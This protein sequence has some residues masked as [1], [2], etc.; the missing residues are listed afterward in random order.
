[1][2]W[3]VTGVYS[4]GDQEILQRNDITRV[5]FGISK[6]HLEKHAR[7]LI[8]ETQCRNNRPGLGNLHNELSMRNR[9]NR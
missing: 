5:G 9:D 3:E 7:H 2:N 6:G 8:Y 1:V 4:L